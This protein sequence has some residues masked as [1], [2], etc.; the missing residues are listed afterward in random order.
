[1]FRL[2]TE[3]PWFCNTATDT[4]VDFC[5]WVLEVD[6]LH[7][8][9]FEYHTGGDGSLRAAGLD[10]ESWQNWLE[11]MIRLKDQSHYAVQRHALQTANDACR[12][13]LEKG[14][15]PND[16]Q[17]EGAQQYMQ[18]HQHEFMELWHQ[19]RQAQPDLLFPKTVVPPETWSGNPAVGKRLSELWEQYELISKRRL[20][21][22]KA[23][24]TT[25]NGETNLWQDLEPY[26]TRLD[27]LMIHFAEYS[28]EQDYPV[29]PRSIV[30]TFVKGHRNHEGFRS[31]VLLAAE[32]LAVSQSS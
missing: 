17:S 11:G 7:V 20:A 3:N 25:G 6:G 27:S 32:A 23:F 9:P 13:L 15:L 29:A 18:T 1:M 28:Q 5:I 26:H 2:G 21:W 4:E 31:R 14:G 30:M 22:G 12:L 19:A 8:S 24:Q 16:P 10:G